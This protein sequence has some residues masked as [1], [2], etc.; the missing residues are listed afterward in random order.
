MKN[1]FF[2]PFA[3][4]ENKNTGVNVKE[5]A[6]EIY[7]KNMCVSLISAKKENP[8]IDVALVT[9]ITI[10]SRYEKLLS[11][12]GVLIFVEPFDSFTFPDNYPWC[13][14]FYKLCALEKMVTKYDYD[15]YMYTDA[16]V[17]VQKSLDKVFFELK[18][19]ILLYDINHGLY[20][21]DYEI[22]VEEFNRFGIDSYITHYGGE[23]FGACRSQAKLFVDECKQ[24]FAEMQEK[25]FITT[26]GDEFILSIAAYKM[27]SCVKN[28]GAYIYRFWTGEFYLVSTCFKYNEI[29]ILHMP[30]EKNNGMIKLFDIFL[31]RQSFPAK[32]KVHSICHLKRPS[33]NTRI[34]QI[35]KQLFR[36]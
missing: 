32:E 26:K 21:K 30:S 1:L 14:A 3:F 33:I 9:N 36:K 31:K 29:V 7:L 34:R 6:K 8:N 23:F 10:P 18:D 16:D 24:I 22:I 11:E 15:N 4:A 19:N 5:N 13:L 12:N 25:D 35:A 27:R 17:F 28:A 20:V 2:V